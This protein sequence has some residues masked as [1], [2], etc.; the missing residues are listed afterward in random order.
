MIAASNTVIDDFTHYCDIRSPIEYLIS[1]CNMLVLLLYS[2]MM[3][4]L[5]LLRLLIR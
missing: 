4:N 2:N 1:T 5:S 3:E